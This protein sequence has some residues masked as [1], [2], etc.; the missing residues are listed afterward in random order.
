MSD[1]ERKD[2]YYIRHPPSYRAKVL[3]QFI[4]KLEAR[5]D[6]EKGTHPRMERRPGSP[7]NKELSSRFKKWTIK[8]E[9]WKSVEE[10]ESSASEA[11]SDSEMS[12]N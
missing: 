10:E 7:I 4:K 1:E 8:K 2:N 3:D 12:E 5:L 9:L 11:S 6:Q